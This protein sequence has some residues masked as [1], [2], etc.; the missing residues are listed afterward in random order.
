MFI[1]GVF[2]SCFSFGLESPGISSEAIGLRSYRF[3][4]PE[5]L[6]FGKTSLIHVYIIKL[7]VLGLLET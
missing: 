2:F 4:N 1:N 6:C 3:L 5:S 7:L